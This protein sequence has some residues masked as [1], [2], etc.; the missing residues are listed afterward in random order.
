MTASSTTHKVQQH[1]S[2]HTSLSTDL[3]NNNNE[4]EDVVIEGEDEEGEFGEFD[5]PSRVMTREQLN[6]ILQENKQLRSSLR[7]LQLELHT[8]LLS[9]QQQQQDVSVGL[10]SLSLEAIGDAVEEQLKQK[11][12]KIKEE[13]HKLREDSSNS[14]SDSNSNNTDSNGN[15]DNENNNTASCRRQ[16]D[17]KEE[18]QALQE[19]LGK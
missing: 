1:S 11:L 4:D 13:L 5:R 17:E 3:R 14:N 15:G 16:L 7:A 18:L 19:Q 9:P 2:L 8:I 12:S 10:E 6:T